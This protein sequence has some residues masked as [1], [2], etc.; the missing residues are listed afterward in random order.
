MSQAP[1]FVIRDN[2]LFGEITGFA[3]GGGDDMAAMD[4]QTL[5]DYLAPKLPSLQVQID[6][7][8]A[9]EGVETRRLGRDEVFLTDDGQLVIAECDDGR[10]FVATVVVG[11]A[12]L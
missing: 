11:A 12:L 1:R 7:L 9:H 3:M 4:A 2:L 10:R 5:Y 8:A 6:Y